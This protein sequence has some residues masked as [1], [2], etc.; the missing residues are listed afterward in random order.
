MASLPS[1]SEEMSI[2]SSDDESWSKLYVV[3]R[4]GP[5]PRCLALYNTYRNRYICTYLTWYSDI[6]RYNSFY[7]VGRTWNRASRSGHGR[8]C[9]CCRRCRRANGATTISLPRQIPR[10]PATMSQYLW[11]GGS[12]TKRVVPVHA[13]PTPTAA[14]S[15]LEW[16]TK[17]AALAN[18]RA[19]VYLW[20][21]V[22][23]PPRE[24]FPLFHGFMCH[25]GV[26]VLGCE[27][28]N[29]L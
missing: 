1:A 17:V 15:L 2:G 16:F 21:S 24:K 9:G 18:Q 23:P 25:P 29:V 26:W 22:S 14:R 13:T 20:Q 3:G 8:V 4:D 19:H 12:H 7:D 27:Y 28:T 5:G 11:S 6:H 10:E